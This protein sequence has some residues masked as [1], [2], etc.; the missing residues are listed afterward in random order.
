M[1]L[2]KVITISFLVISIGSA[3]TLAACGGSTEGESAQQAPTP[4]LGNIPATA[5]PDDPSVSSSPENG[6]DEVVTSEIV[7]FTPAEEDRV[8]RWRGQNWKTDF[9][10]RIVS[11]EDVFSGGVPRD[12]IPP[13]DNPA[14]DRVSVAPDY[15]IPNEPVIAVEAD[16]DASAYPLSIL[17]WHEI[18]N[19]TLGQ[20]KIS[21]TYCPLCNSAIVFDRMLNGLEHTFGVSGNLLNSDLI[22]YDRQTESW[23]QQFT[24][25]AIVGEYVASNT[26]LDVIPS[27]IISWSAFKE[28]YPDGRVLRRPGPPLQRPY[29]RPPY[30]EY[31][32]SAGR[33][34]LFGGDLDDR[35]RPTERVLAI[36]IKEDTVAYSWPFLVENPVTHGTLGDKEFVIFFDDGTLSSFRDSRNEAYS[37]GSAAAFDRTVDGRQLTFT[38]TSRGIEDEETSSLWSPAGLAVEGALAGQTLQPIPHGNHFWF[39]WD[40]FFPEAPLIDLQED[41]DSAANFTEEEQSR[42]VRWRGQRWNTDFTK[43]TVSLESVFFGSVPRDGIPSIDKPNFSSADNTPNYLEDEEP[44]VVFE[45]NGEARAYPLSILIRHEIVNDDVGGSRISVTY[46]PLCNSAIVFDRVVDERELTFGVAGGLR[47]NDLIMYDRETQSWWQ[48][49]TGEAIVGDYAGYNTVLT[50]LPST[51]L[52]LKDFRRRY[53]NGD[54]LQRDRDDDRFYLSAPYA[55]YDNLTEGT[56]LILDNGEQ[57]PVRALERVLAIQIEG[58]TVAYAWPYLKENIVTHGKAGD[59]EFVVFFDDATLSAYRDYRASGKP[60]GSAAA[61][62]TT[63]DGQRLTFS[64][65]SRGI[66]DNET[67]SLWSTAGLAIE[68]ELSGKVLAPVPQGSHFWFAWA[69][70]FPDIML[71]TEA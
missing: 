16:G 65:T 48:Q 70:F 23:W 71:T 26:T 67:G 52:S 49:I 66:E 68:G 39:S 69:V 59:S 13:I 20:Q 17:V 27:T 57:S 28:R 2:P 41:T 3:L 31:D 6:S 24:G 18:V 30:A 45:S 56:P 29:D 40:A 60:S 4:T 22:M 15:L 21:V 19:D 33:P 64:T 53:P 9:T 36:Q 35:L 50:P 42:V 62:Y 37:S 58:N 11:F 63:V 43:R 61:Y 47:N 5:T 7:P 12:G 8:N 54:I 25:Q 55:G 32:L 51:I 1:L 14:F 46:C 10:Q 34:F 44:V 38:L